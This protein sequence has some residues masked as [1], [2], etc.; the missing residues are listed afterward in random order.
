MKLT[1]IIGGLLFSTLLVTTAKG[2]CSFGGIP[3]GN[4]SSLN[5]GQTSTISCMY[6]GEYA[7]VSVVSGSNYTFSTCGGSWDSQLTLFTSTG[8]FLAY[9]DDFCGLQ[10]QINW[11]ATFTGQVRVKLNRYYCS[12][13]SSCMNLNVTRGAAPPANPCNSVV[14]LSCGSSQSYTLASGNGAWNPS[15]GPWGTPGKEQVYSFTPTISGTH[16]IN[17]THSGGGW[18]DLFI[19]SGSSC[20]QNGWVYIDDIFTSATNSV[21]LNAGTTYYFLLD[22][23]NI[24]YSSGSISIDCPV[25]VADPCNS[26]QTLTCDQNASY[27]L[28]SGNGAWDPSSGPWGT[29]GK[30]QVY[31]YTPAISANYDITVSHNSSGWVDLFYSSSACGSQGWNYVDDIL[32]SA[33]NS[34]YLVGGTTYYFLIDDE[35]TSASSGTITIACPCIG[36]QVDLAVSLSGPVTLYENTSGACNDC[37]LRSSEDITFALTIPCSGTYTF[38]TCDLASWDT[39]LYLTSQPCSGI[40]A[41]NDDNCSLRSSITYTFTSGGVYY[42]TV[43]GFSSSSGGAF[44][45]DITRSCDLSLSLNPDVKGCGYNVS[46]NGGNDGEITATTDGGCGS[47]NYVWSNGGNA[48]V[49]SGVGAG[50]YTLTVSD[51]WGCSAN[52]SITLTEPSPI[53]ISTTSSGTVYYGYGPYS[54]ADITANAGGGC[55]GYQYDWYEAGNLIY[56]GASANVCPQQSTDYDVVVTDQNGCT[57]TGSVNVCVVDVTCYAGNSGNQKVEMCHVPHGNPGNTQDICIDASAVPAHLAHGCTI[58]SCDEVDACTNPTA[59]FSQ[60]DVVGSFEIQDD[61]DIYPNPTSGELF[62]EMEV[63]TEDEYSVRLLNLE[64]KELLLVEEST[65]LSS[66]FHSWRLNLNELPNGVYLIRVDRQNDAST[67]RRVVKQ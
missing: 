7:T 51:D 56:S 48:A 20:N 23:E 42:L 58:G 25:P 44:G 3:Y 37:G 6:G 21:S 66:G 16:Q 5:P 22:D 31:S 67:F 35:N 59:R 14:A 64:G 63:S 2:Q 24:S 61:L 49:N 19:K 36:S 47:M 12:S 13:Y 34:V 55:A 33:T 62:I 60:E 4:I 65:L 39:Y 54:C 53:S 40:L 1:K 11:T 41:S 15:S 29:P 43:E 57:A 50:N 27:S 32:S 8:T 17:V 28:S 52:E 9:N 38:E 18:V 10:S 30:E 46:C 26:I 45:L